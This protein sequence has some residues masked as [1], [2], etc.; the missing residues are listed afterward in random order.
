M[1]RRNWAAKLLAILGVALLA[2]V[3]AAALPDHPYQRWQLIE[4]TLYGN[5][6]WSYER[7]HF[8]PRP[9]DVAIIG[10]SRAQLG[11][12]APRV[13][14]RLAAA[15]VPLEVANL[16]VIEEGRNI[17]W[18][19]ADELFK[20]KRPKVLVL[21]ISE[22]YNLWGHPGFKY[23]APGGALVSPPAP[24][25]HNSLGDLAYL[26][27][28]QLMLFAASLAPSLFDLRDDF[29]PERYAAK[30]TDYS[31]T[32]VL[33]DGKRIDMDR[34]VSADDLRAEARAFAAVRRP[35]R[36]PARIAAVT[37]R[38]NSVYVAAIARLA[39]RHGA[40]LIFIFLPEFDGVTTIEGRA[41]Y[42]RLGR[43][44]DF[45]DLAHDSSWFQS[46]AHLNHRGAMIASDRLA[47][48]IIADL[49]ASA[50]TG[51][52]MGSGRAEQRATRVADDDTAATVN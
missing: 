29:D 23:V 31:Q 27:Y 50:A 47:A 17:E 22:R 49:G 7:I 42:A 12:S 14:E 39:A 48:A 19:I 35:S 40:R 41:N 3:G 1:R 11:L 45:G 5:A 21:S 33:A 8:D 44:E 30:P 4:N 43:V 38:D 34:T 9:V 15:G 6:T 46:F 36:L 20:V 28:R 25:L 2:A 18:A 16:S 52:R 51:N 26:P 24:L 10:A 37:D 32:R 13:A